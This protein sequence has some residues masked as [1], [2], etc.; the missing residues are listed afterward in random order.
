MLTSTRSSSLLFLMLSLSLCSHYCTPTP[1]SVSL[2]KAT[3]RLN[4][5]VVT[6]SQQFNQQH[7]Q[8]IVKNVQV[9]RIY[10]L[11]AQ[12]LN[13][14]D[15]LPFFCRFV[16]PR[17]YSEAY[18]RHWC[19]EDAIVAVNNGSFPFNFLR[20]LIIMYIC[21]YIINLVP[22][23]NVTYPLLSPLLL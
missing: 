20:I 19:S 23:K 3:G 12:H 17:S 1:D 16:D 4:G 18:T 6:I 15:I 13:I 5:I 22:S 7:C 9:W 14:T 8:E 21:M 10:Y 11:D 2:D